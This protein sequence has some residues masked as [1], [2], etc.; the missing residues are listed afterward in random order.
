MLKID[1]ILDTFKLY[2]KSTYSNEV[3]ISGEIH[4]YDKAGNSLTVT[5]AWK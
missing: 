5:D 4:L 1:Q 3:S 2:S